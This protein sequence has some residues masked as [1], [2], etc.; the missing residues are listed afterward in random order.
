MNEEETPATIGPYCIIDRLGRGGMGE[1][2]LAYDATC[3]RQVALKRIRTD[4]V[5]H[6]VLHERFL[7]EAKI[8]SQLSHPAIIPV[9][10]LDCDGD[11]V[12]YTM[13]FIEGETLRQI[14]R[15]TREKEKAGL[16][17]DTLGN[18]LRALCRIFLQV[19]QAAAYAHSRGVLHRDFKPENIIIGPYGE[20]IILDWGLAKAVEEA[21]DL[22]KLPSALIDSKNTTNLGHPIGTIAYMAP[23][24]AMGAPASVLTDIYALGVMFYQLLTLRLPFR[25]KTLK[26]FRKNGHLERLRNPTS[27]APYRDISQ[28][29]CRIAEKCLTKDA[30][31]RYQTVDALIADLE[32]YLEGRSDWFPI[33]ELD[34]NNKSDWEFQENLFLAEHVA[35]MGT[36][37]EAEWVSM[38]VS[39]AS[40]SGNTKLEMKVCLEEESHG[41]GIL[42]SIPEASDP[43]YF[44]KGYCLWLGT[45]PQS[46][47][48]LLRGGIEVLAIPD[49]TFQSNVCY[50]IL[51]EKVDDNV[52]FSINGKQKYSYISH[53]PL[54]GTHVGLFYRDANFSINQFKVFIGSVQSRLSCLA[55]PDA[56]LANKNFDKA[57]G[58]YRRIGNSF[59][60]RD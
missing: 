29:L 14:L 22:E 55:V 51:L 20:V 36:T 45:N 48:R 38:M 60:G 18:S 19:C 54:V 5:K 30:S 16:E 8:T 23:E 2:F 17:P 27:V 21:L 49:L 10:S 58:E 3:E 57:L 43:Y 4:L 50:S 24:R 35:L 53:A 34:I 44:T 47:T 31:E 6:Q 42:L 1:V 25:R 28:M 59:T 9:Y 32:N 46:T 15:R 7:R 39:K 33:C 26:E 12:Y 37:A 13:P 52:F 11:A 56:F 41:I 40:F